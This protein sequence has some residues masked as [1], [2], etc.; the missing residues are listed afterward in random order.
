VSGEVSEECCR[1]VVASRPRS[2]PLPVTMRA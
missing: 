1:P 2:T